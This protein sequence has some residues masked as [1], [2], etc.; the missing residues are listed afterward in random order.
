MA[1][2]DTFTTYRMADGTE[3]FGE[4]AFMTEDDAFEE[5]AEDCGDPL[6]VIREDWVLRE[7]RTITYKPAG[8]D[9]R[10]AELAEEAA[11]EAAP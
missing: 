5:W 3:V 10:Q 11:Q 2:S 6:E 7:R 4:Y 1:D 9:E 8:W